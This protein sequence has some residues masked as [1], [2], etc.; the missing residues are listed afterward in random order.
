MAGKL[1]PGRPGLDLTGRLLS[2]KPK[3]KSG[4]LA[5]CWP[6]YV[7]FALE[8]AEAG[9]VRIRRQADH[10]ARLVAAWL[11]LPIARSLA[12]IS[13]LSVHQDRKWAPNQPN[14]AFS[15]LNQI[16]SDRIGSQIKWN[17]IELD[18]IESGRIGADWLR[19]SQRSAARNSMSQF[20]EWVN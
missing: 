20:N 19:L 16:G 3:A 5:G 17:T 9:V 15:R 2:Q 14:S 12:A 7:A 18:W 6:A 4:P 11:S 10:R 1:H 13:I 8:P